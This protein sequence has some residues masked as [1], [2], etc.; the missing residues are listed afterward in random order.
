MCVEIKQLMDEK[1]GAID[2][3]KVAGITRNKRKQQNSNISTLKWCKQMWF[4]PSLDSDDDH[5]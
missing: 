2:S 5:E 1:R 3:A 4:P